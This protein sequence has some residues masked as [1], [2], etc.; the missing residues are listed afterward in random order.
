MLLLSIF[1]ILIFAQILIL[2]MISTRPAMQVAGN[3]KSSGLLSIKNT[4][5]LYNLYDIAVNFTET[6][7]K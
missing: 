7:L 4:V 3:R 1:N 2:R 5:A 6:L